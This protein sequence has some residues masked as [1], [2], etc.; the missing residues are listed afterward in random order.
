MKGGAMPAEGINPVDPPDY[1]WDLWQHFLCL[2]A[3]RPPGMGPGPIL[4][5]EIRAYCLNRDLRFE[6][7]ELDALRALD[8]IA[9][10]SNE[11]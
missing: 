10:R 3:N 11:G 4:E 7:W 5:S 2:N 1:L 9:L 6:R 8:A